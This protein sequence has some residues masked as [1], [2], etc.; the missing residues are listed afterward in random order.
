MRRGAT[1][2]R[3]DKKHIVFNQMS[4]AGEA[5]RSQ[6]YDT[7]DTTVHDV[8]I[9]GKPALLMIREKDHFASIAWDEG[10]MVYQIAG[11]LSPEEAVKMAESL[12]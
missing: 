9:N 10:V 8:L 1:Y 4:V 6:G 12:E 5:V 11:I 7:D 3:Q 2:T